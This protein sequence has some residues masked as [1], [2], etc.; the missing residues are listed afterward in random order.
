MICVFQFFIAIMI[1]KK[2]DVNLIKEYL[3][4]AWYPICYWYINVFVIIMAIVK[5]LTNRKG[6]FVVWESPDR[7]LQQT[8]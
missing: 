6:K 2:Y 5:A 1:D 7:C 8:K 3:W 4:A